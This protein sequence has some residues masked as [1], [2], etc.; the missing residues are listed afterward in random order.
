MGAKLM[1]LQTIISLL[2]MALVLLPA[3]AQTA[4]DLESDAISAATPP[5]LLLVIMVDDSSTMN[6]NLSSIETAR[7]GST[8][9]GTDNS[10]LRWQN[11]GR[12]VTQLHAD[13]QTTHQVGVLSF[14][15]SFRGWYSGTSDAPF[16]ELG[17]QG[18]D[19]A[20][21]GLMTRINRADAGT[22]PGDTV[23]AMTEVNNAL[24]RWAQSFGRNSNLKPVILL[25]TDDVPIEAWSESPWQLASPWR[26]GVDPLFK[27][28]VTEFTRIVN[29]QGTYCRHNNGSGILYTMALGAANWVNAD[30]SI[31]QSGSGNYFQQIALQNNFTSL[32]TGEPLVSV[33][34]AQMA[35][36]T[37]LPAFDFETAFDNF[38]QEVRC[39]ETTEQRNITL[40]PFVSSMTIVFQQGAD[41]NISLTPPDDRPVNSTNDVIFTDAGVRIVAPRGERA[42]YQVWS[43]DRDDWV[44]SG[45][46]W[47]GEW[48]TDV[49]T[50]VLRSIT[51][52]ATELNWQVVGDFNDEL[53][54]LTI[55]LL[56]DG[57]ALRFSPYIQS[58]SAVLENQQNPAD[59]Q[60]YEF[61]QLDDGT[62]QL[63][64]PIES[65]IFTIEPYITMGQAV[66][67]TDIS[68]G[69]VVRLPDVA[70]N[71]NDVLRIARTTIEPQLVVQDPPLN[72]SLNPNC[73]AEGVI[74]FNVDIGF[75]L[76]DPDPDLLERLYSY[77]RVEVYHSF[78]GQDAPAPDATPIAVLAGNLQ[79]SAFTARE[80]CAI[81]DARARDAGTDDP[82]AVSTQQVFEYRPVSNV[83]IDLP[84]PVTAVF[85]YQTP[86]PTP[87]PTVTPQPSPTRSIPTPPA[88][89]PVSEVG[90]V[91]TSPPGS[92]L[93]TIGGVLVAIL[94]IL[95]GVNNYARL[96]P[97]RA[98]SIDRKDTDGDFGNLQAI[99]TGFRRYLPISKVTIYAD[100]DE[101]TQPLFDI[102]ANRE[103][104]RG[105]AHVRLDIGLMSVPADETFELFGEINDIIA[106]VDEQQTYIFRIVDNDPIRGGFDDYAR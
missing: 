104:L 23:T 99:V 14:D 8:R 40:S 24:Q 54:Q 39:L 70:A 98:V 32:Q 29:Y 62:Y 77:V 66:I 82:Q 4:T 64:I 5:G 87:M 41:R 35:T 73:S 33:I 43:F 37:T 60:T 94:L 34:D 13:T 81:L 85:D 92:V 2:F 38:L 42:P 53:P 16:V 101:Q 7:F 100:D 75:G 65:G 56:K 58:V 26:T 88:V 17:A 3:H 102:I 89:N 61:N 22:L 25:I 91:L 79:E 50:R 106:R 57:R 93:F 68:A 11:V 36:G 105:Y 69:T 55:Q 90:D 1:R 51:E 83:D 67:G 45:R 27:Q 78:D 84:L 76:D 31:N 28:Q 48:Q 96:L 10:M 80:P 47:S 49:Q 19:N 20:Y 74:D 18:N 86:T 103:A 30:G 6:D 97:L 71:R 59:A 15:N 44:A 12:I 9:N 95:S 46:T 21:N 72:T 63:P 52:D